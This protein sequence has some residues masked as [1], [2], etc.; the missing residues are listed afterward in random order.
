MNFT[1]GTSLVVVAME[2][3]GARIDRWIDLK[4]HRLD[5][6]VDD[7]DGTAHLVGQRGSNLILKVVIGK[8]ETEI[9]TRATLSPTTM[10]LT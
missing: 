1:L 9:V 8:N 5:A 10:A 3:A 2:G 4:V 7:D 6:A